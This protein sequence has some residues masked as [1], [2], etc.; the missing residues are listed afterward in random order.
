M[1]DDWRSRGRGYRL[2]STIPTNTTGSITHIGDDVE[3]SEIHQHEIY[4]RLS[5]ISPVQLAS[6]THEP[7]SDPLVLTETHPS[8]STSIH[9]PAPPVPEPEHIHEPVGHHADTVGDIDDI[10]DV[11]EYFPIYILYYKPTATEPATIIKA[12]SMS[13]ILDRAYTEAYE[14]EESHGLDHREKD[15][16]TISLGTNYLRKDRLV[17][18]QLK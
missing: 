10:G 12:T 6:Q 11:E 3:P 14:Y 4:P 8:V 9:P 18:S 2:S 7:V 5:P 17:E 16:I 13:D 1:S 15:V